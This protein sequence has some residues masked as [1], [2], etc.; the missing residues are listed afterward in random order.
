MPFLQNSNFSA[1]GIGRV[2]LLNLVTDNGGSKFGFYAGTITSIGHKDTQTGQTWTWKKQN[3]DVL[4]ILDF[5]A[6]AFNT[7]GPALPA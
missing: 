6:D 3:D 5:T 1:G 7:P 4:N 2:S